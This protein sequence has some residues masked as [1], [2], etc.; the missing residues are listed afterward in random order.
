MKKITVLGS[1][2]SIGCGALDVIGRNRDSFR[3]VALTAGRNVD[4]LARQIRA[5]SPEIVAVADRKTADALAGKVKGPEILWGPDGINAVA[6]Y[7]AADLVISSIVGSAGLMPT[8]SAI[9]AG[10]TIGLAN[11]EALV[12]AGEVVMAEARKHRARIIPVDSEHS[13]IFQCLA[14]CGK[15]GVSRIILTASGGPFLNRKHKDLKRV[16]AQDALKHPNW[17]MG[18]KITV[19][20]ATL[21]NKGLEVIEAHWLFK[22]P[23]DRIGV[24]IHP[25]SIVHS[26]VE[27]TDRSLLAQ[28]STPDMRGPISYALSYPKRIETPIACLELDLIGAL[29]FHRPDVDTFPCLA[30]AYEALRAGGT[31]PGV[32]NAANELAV[33]AFLEG[34]I[35]FT[36]IPEVI[37]KTIDRHSSDSGSSLDTV[38]QADLWA[39]KTAQRLIRE[40]QQ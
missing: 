7:P 34:R 29:T 3:I 35:G 39:R 28:M 32:L 31:V 33:N 2:G 24:L 5:F 4:L 30:Y 37:R 40:I 21:M 26:M 9:R 36:D 20:S 19:D 38:T 8:I 1:T 14:G 27:F 18:R 16:T 10:K 23:P 25:Q 15:T 12:M 13:A 22:M 11:K 6:A 17:S